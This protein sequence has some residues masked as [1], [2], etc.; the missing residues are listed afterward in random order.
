[1]ISYYNLL[2][3]ITNSYKTSPNRE[4]YDFDEYYIDDEGKK[5]NNPNFDRVF[6]EERYLNDHIR[7]ERNKILI[8]T[9]KLMIPDYPLTDS[10]KAILKQ[11]RKDLRD[12]PGK[13]KQSQFKERGFPKV[14]NFL[15]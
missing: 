13:V 1:M 10:D 14:P 4:F 7:P 11:Y 3:E 12:L 15:N 2:G 8:V 5:I 9:D 6:Q